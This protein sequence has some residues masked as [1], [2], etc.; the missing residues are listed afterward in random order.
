MD[1]IELKVHVGALTA[2]E[3]FG[4]G[5]KETSQVVRKRV[6]AARQLQKQRFA[7]GQTININARIPGGEVDA[8]CELDASALAAMREVAS[9]VTQMTTRGHDT[10]LK[11]ARTIADLNNSRCIYKKHIVEAAE[12]C[13]HK[14]VRDFLAAQSEVVLCA[15]CGGEV[16]SS[17]SFCKRCGHA[18]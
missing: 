16:G 4:A 12:L 5:S 3:R 14:E 18:I 7:N 13:D 10:L 6:E 15:A 17:D 11:V 1:R 2:E 9:R 8:Y